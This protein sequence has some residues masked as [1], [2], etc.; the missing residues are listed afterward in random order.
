MDCI[1]FLYDF[2]FYDYV[3]DKVKADPTNYAKFYGGG[4][5]HPDHYLGNDVINSDAWGESLYVAPTSSYDIAKG[6]IK[7]T[8]VFEGAGNQADVYKI[9]VTYKVP[10]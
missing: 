6:E 3:Y 4:S 7:F 5:I 10:D 1:Q 9:E 2:P 8:F